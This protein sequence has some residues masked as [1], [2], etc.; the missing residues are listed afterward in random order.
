MEFKSKCKT[1]KA[2]KEFTL[3]DGTIIGV[4]QGDRGMEKQVDIRICYKDK[5]TKSKKRTPK[6]IHWVID[7]LIKKEHDKELTLRFVK[8]LRDMYN[9]VKPFQN[10]A[11]QQRCEL[12]ETT[13]EKL[14]EFEPLNQYGEYT[15]E[16][17]GHLIELMI[18]MEKNHRQPFVFKDLLDA[19]INGK[20]IFVIVSKATQIGK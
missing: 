4:F 8:Y 13:K 9:R 6:H 2:F 16:F 3:S 15:V 18:I 11:E 14:K 12:K 5:F 19:I 1:H 20:E 7:L 17:I 10:K